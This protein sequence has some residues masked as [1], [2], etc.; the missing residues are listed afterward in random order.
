MDLFSREQI[1]S[2]TLVDFINSAS[3]GCATYVKS[4]FEDYQS[5]A[6]TQENNI[7]LLTVKIAG[8]FI[9]NVYKPPNDQW[10]ENLVL[11]YHP[12][13]YIGNFN[14]WGYAENDRNGLAL[15]SWMELNK[16]HLVFDGKTRKSFYSARWKKEYNPDL[17]F[18]TI[19]NEVP[20]QASRD[21][22]SGF[23][24]SQ[25]RPVIAK[26]GNEIKQFPSLQKPRWNFQKAK[27][28]EFAKQVDSDLRWIPPTSINYHRF[29]GAIKN[30]AK[31]FIPRGFRKNYVP[32]WSDETKSFYNAYVSN[33]NPENADA[34]LNSFNKARKEKW[35]NLMED[36]NFTHSSRSSWKLL[37][38]LGSSNIAQ[39]KTD[40]AISPNAVASRL[41]NVSN[42]V[43]LEKRAKK[44]M[45]RRV[46][47]QRKKMKVS[48]ELSRC[49]NVDELK[50]AISSTK[51][52]KSAGF[53]GIY[54][55]FIKNLGSFALKWLT[56]LFN[57]IFYFS[58]FAL[59][60]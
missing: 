49:F 9:I 33:P 20:L 22:L 59:R 2:Y 58:P 41:V 7:F 40:S 16:L 28:N 30:A 13:I 60:V 3:Y 29:V 35:N 50:A 32:C 53:D 55:E 11:N 17:C 27:W 51:S 57:D 23:P 47:K 38:K 1:P 43:K 5:I 18:V 37:Q 25:H 14:L 4:N 39:P 56:F 24:H 10:P 15:V 21:V 19:N 48:E 31:K 44:E 42:S 26:I 36:L 34:V 54:P 46:Q 12:A 6:K 8:I 52:K 45:K